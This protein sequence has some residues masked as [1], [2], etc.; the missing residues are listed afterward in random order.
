MNRELFV[1]FG[2]PVSHSKSPVMHNMAFKR[3]GYPGCYGRYRLEDGSKLR[4]MFFKLELRGCNITV[5]HKE[6]AYKACDKLDSFAKRVGAVNTIIY[7]ENQLQ[8]YNTDAPGFLKVLKTMLPNGGKIL[9]IVA[10]GTAQSTSVILRESGYEVEI[11]NRSEGR[12]KQFIENGF[13]CYTYDSFNGDGYDIVVNMTSAGLKDNSLPAPKE[14]L[15]RALSK[16]I[17]VID[18]VYGSNTPFLE[19]A[20]TKGLKTK[21]GSDMLLYQG[22]LAFNYFTNEKYDLKDIEYAMRYGLSL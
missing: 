10:G 18:V 9:F 8:G 12:L 11:L 1:I 19:F 5:P 20:K 15:N 2:D 17:G 14:I 6:Y 16:A 21:D 22:V 4:D 7:K 13:E 3:V